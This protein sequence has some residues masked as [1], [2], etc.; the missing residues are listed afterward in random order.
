MINFIKGF[1][2]AI[3]YLCGAIV[4]LG[5]FFLFSYLT[6]MILSFCLMDLL[7]G[8]IGPILIILTTVGLVGGVYA[9]VKN[10]H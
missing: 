3:I 7:K 9:C 1:I 6:L 4:G 8:G 5:I 10:N 2:K